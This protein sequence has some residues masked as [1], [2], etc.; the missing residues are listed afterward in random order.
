[1][2][3][4]DKGWQILVRS[5]SGGGVDPEQRGALE[6]W[7]ATPHQ[8]LE[9]L[10]RE[11]G[12]STGLLVTDR[13]LRLIHAPLCGSSSTKATTRPRRWRRRSPSI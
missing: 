4:P 10:L 7:E 3:D 13:E 5:E 8:Q 1:V 11:S 6:G 2:T 12:V 9:R